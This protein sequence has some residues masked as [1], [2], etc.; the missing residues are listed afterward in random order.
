MIR[1]MALLGARLAIGGGMA[2]HGAQKALG[3]FGGPGPEKAGQLMESLGFRPGETFGALASW[4]EIGS[5]F[6]IMAGFGG[7]IGPAMLIS[8]MIVAQAT[9]HAPNGFFAQDGGIE[10][11]VVYS[12]AALVFASTDYGSL[13][14]D[15]VT[16]LNK[17][18]HH[19]WLTTLV[20]TGGAAAAIVLLNS[21]NTT[22]NGEA[23]PT[24]RGT[25]SPAAEGG[26][27]NEAGGS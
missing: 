16:G 11:G 19:P 8:N 14:L 18:L 5:G 26:S 4:N 7:P 1:D 9:V 25:N 27:A 3:W 6:L 13:S 12:S 17:K 20:L 24:F 21:R 22:P 2:A 10:L 23:S 15:A